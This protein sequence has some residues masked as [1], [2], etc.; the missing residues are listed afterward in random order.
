M[1]RRRR[2]RFTELS[3][4]A[5]K[6]GPAA[7]FVSHTWGARFRELAAAIAY[8]LPPDALVWLDI[9]AVRQW[10]GNVGDIDF[11]PVVHKTNALLLIARHL[12]QVGKGGAQ[13]VPE[14]GRE[15]KE[16]E[17]QEGRYRTRGA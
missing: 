2:C 15:H 17:T 6:T 16:E 10:P 11:R 12:Q 13:R 5:D 7:V 14:R 8:A 3:Q 1:T 9:F 4:M